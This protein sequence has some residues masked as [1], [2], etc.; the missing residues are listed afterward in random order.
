MEELPEVVEEAVRLLYAAKSGEKLGPDEAIKQAIENVTAHESDSDAYDDLLWDARP[1][2]KE[3]Q[4]EIRLASNPTTNGS[5]TRLRY[6]ADSIPNARARRRRLWGSP[7]PLFPAGNDD[8]SLAK[9]LEQVWAWVSDSPEVKRYSTT[10]TTEVKADGSE[11][12]TARRRA[13]VKPIYLPKWVEDRFVEMVLPFTCQAYKL[14]DEVNGFVSRKAERAP[15]WRPEWTAVYLATG[16]FERI[17]LPRWVVSRAGISAVGGKGRGYAYIEV[18]DVGSVSP[19]ELADAYNRTR[20]K[21]SDTFSVPKLEITAGRPEEYSTEV[22]GQLEL[23]LIAN[24]AFE[25]FSIGKSVQP[26]R[27]TYRPGHR[28]LAEAWKEKAAG[29]RVK[30]DPPRAQSFSNFKSRV[31]R[32]LYELAIKHMLTEDERREII[33]EANRV[34]ERAIE[35][36][37]RTP[38]E[39]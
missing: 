1:R 22:L 13:I 2:V 33:E 25:R 30:V 5:L 20:Q 24:Q 38:K 23:E 36:F 12:E 32:D 9:A 16:R 18:N 28:E 10:I 37:K 17:A 26:D 27:W 3:R 8:K 21:L 31:R 29:L 35:A 11:T 39:P 7:E 4:K 15:W 34:E 19:S 6:L 14:S